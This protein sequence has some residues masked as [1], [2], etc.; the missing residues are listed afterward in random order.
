MET[1]EYHYYKVVKKMMSEEGSAK[2]R[3]LIG[4]ATGIVETTK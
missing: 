4:E 3:K 2:A 1:S